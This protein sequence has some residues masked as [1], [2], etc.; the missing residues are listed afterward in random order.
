MRRGR[1][2][3]T[4]TGQGSANAMH[5]STRPRTAAAL[6]AV[7]VA[8]ALLA[9]PAQ[10]GSGCRQIAVP[11]EP[12]C[13]P[14]LPD[15][16]WGV[17]HRNSYAQASSPFRGLR[18]AR[19]E[20]RHIDLPGI[21][22]QTQFSSR[23]RDGGIAAWGSLVDSADRRAVYKI[24]ATTGRLIDLYVPGEREADPPPAGQGGITGSYNILDRDGNFIVP[25]QKVIDVFAD[26]RRGVRSSPIRLVKRFEL[27]PE[28]FCRP[29][30]RIAGATMTYDGY[31]AFVTEQGIVGTVPRDPEFMTTDTLRLLSLN[32]DACGNESVA[33]GDLE[34]VS[35]SI[36][37]DEDGGIYVVTSENMRRINHDAASNRLHSEWKAP[38][39]PGSGQ[40]AIRLGVGSG[41][42]PT[43]M[44]TGRQDKLVAITDG[45]DLMHLNLFW[46]DRVPGNWRGLGDGRPRRMACDYPVRFGDRRA[47]FSISEQS[48][49]VRSYATFHVNNLLD[50]DF[51]GV[52]AGPLRNVLAALR[53]GDPEAA[54]HGAE[55]IDWSARKRRCHSVWANRRVSI[56]NGIPAMSS[57]TGSAYGIGQRNGRW[58]VESLSWRTGAS[59]FFARAEPH[60]CSDTV[61][62]YLDNSGLRS[63]FDPVLA[64]LPQSCENS[65]YAA[66]E[67]GPGST[68]WTGTFLGLTIYRPR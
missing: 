68:I 49:T 25:R 31:V 63:V 4:T 16:P 47:R 62:G 53:G 56:P 34:A 7:I 36:A 29:E 20:T 55:R 5:R 21:P 41:S 12:P 46:R 52:P 45:R 64:E 50:Y 26:S 17:S 15:S 9:A 61:L 42:T 65:V 23:Y 40:S 51:S 32:R 39:D 13:N 60:V 1:T 59:R 37:A 18:N 43:V 38:Y 30:D 44:G 27:P 10:A 8:V 19:V 11:N 22:I 2:V 54:P 24:D 28:A 14:A 35:N 3:R 66:T 57:A 48:L 58:G 6:A 67:I 33:A